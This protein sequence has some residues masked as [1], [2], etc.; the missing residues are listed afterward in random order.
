MDTQSRNIV[1]CFDGTSNEVVSTP[2][3]VLRLCRCLVKDEQQIV[4]YTPGVGT[5]MDPQAI[6]DAKKWF[7]KL[8]DLAT[9]FSLGESACAGYAFLVRN[10]RPGDKVF[11][12]G[13]SRGSY[14]ARAMVGMLN[15]FGLLQRANEN[16]VTY[17]WQWFRSNILKQKSSLAARREFFANARRYKNLFAAGEK[18]EIELVGVFD[19][20][21]S[22]LSTVWHPFWVLAWAATCWFWHPHWLIQAAV[23]LVGF[24]LSFAV[25]FR[26]LP[27]TSSLP[28][29][30]QVRHAIALDE[31]RA[32]F[33]CNHIG[34]QNPNHIEVWFSGVHTDVGGGR[35]ED[36]SQLAKVSLEWMLGEAAALGV[37]VDPAKVQAVLKGRDPQ[38][39]CGRSMKWYW[40]IA[41][42]VPQ[43]RFNP[44]NFSGRESGQARRAG[45][46]TS[47][48]PAK[49]FRSYWPNFWR[50]RYIRD[51]D[52][53]H[54]S[55]ALRYQAGI[56]KKPRLDG[57]SWNQ[58]GVVYNQPV[59]GITNGFPPPGAASP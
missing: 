20:V 9:G 31:Y 14:A 54:A 53:I 8:W 43:I 16:L 26:W 39:E 35:A 58:L 57:P 48:K 3:N 50:Y 12:F 5:L 23:Y 34:G 30:K 29:A 24:I 46:S 4:Y 6:T 33:P 59:P 13:F 2:T 51:G 17:L 38:G 15:M 21:S 55:V 28:N 36:Q 45:T 42:I 18:V 41:G 22:Y 40:L 25:L 56:I 1:L 10:Y 27:Y 44:R 37:R 52:R 32:F 11:V 7:R 49:P 47:A 19:T